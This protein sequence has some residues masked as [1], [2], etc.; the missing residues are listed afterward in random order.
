ML[1]WLRSRRDVGLARRLTR[2][3]RRR[4]G[5]RGVPEFIPHDRTYGYLLGVDRTD[6]ERVNGYDTRFEGW[7]EEDVD[8]AVRASPDRPTLRAC[9]AR[10]HADPP[11]ARVG[12]PRRT[13]E[14]VPAADD[15][16]KRS[17]RGCRR[18]P[19][20]PRATIED[21]GDGSPA[22]IVGRR[23]LSDWA[24]PPRK[25]SVSWAVR[26]SRE[27]QRSKAGSPRRGRIPPASHGTGQ[28]RLCPVDSGAQRHRNQSSSHAEA[29]EV[30]AEPI[31]VGPLDV[32]IDLEPDGEDAPCERVPRNS[33]APSS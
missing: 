9:R 8:I 31:V 20:A 28:R 2:R 11:L 14:L 25:A 26:T 24:R 12:H 16:R 23:A 7:G 18:S 1:E 6:F 33:S 21:G 13:A 4:V 10:R 27:A 32:A 17:G 19:R 30:E 22:A 15:R 29:A 3:D 5:A